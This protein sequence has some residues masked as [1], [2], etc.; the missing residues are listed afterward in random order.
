MRSNNFIEVAPENRE[1][2]KAHDA[3]RAADSPPGSV[4]A[5]ENPAANSMLSKAPPKRHGEQFN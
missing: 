1:S 2:L 3:T 4:Y 5:L